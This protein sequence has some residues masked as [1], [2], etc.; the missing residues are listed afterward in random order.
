MLRIS[1]DGRRALAI[2]GDETSAR[3]LEIATGEVLGEWHPQFFD[4]RWAC[5]VIFAPDGEHGY[6]TAMTKDSTGGEL[7]EFD[8][9]TGEETR[10]FPLPSDGFPCGLALHPD[11]KTI[12]QVTMIRR[13]DGSEIPLELNWWD[14]DSARL[15]RHV[16]I[17]TS[18]LDSPVGA[19]FQSVFS[20]DGETLVTAFSESGLVA[21]WNTT[22]GALLQTVTVESSHRIMPHIV[23]SGLLLVSDLKSRLATQVT[24]WDMRTGE[25]LNEQ[26]WE[27]N[28]DASAVSPDGQTLAIGF[29]AA[30]IA[31][32]DVERWQT[33]T[34]LY[35]H[36]YRVW[37]L[38]FTPDGQFLLSGSADGTL[39]LWNLTNGSERLRIDGL[40]NIVGAFDLSPDGSRAAI[41]E[42]GADEPARLGLWDLETGELIR[43]LVNTQ[44]GWR[45]SAFSPDGRRIASL[46][47]TTE[48]FC[49]DV[50]SSLVLTDVDTGS[51]LWQV[52]IDADIFGT[53]AFSGD[54][55]KIFVNEPCEG[56]SMLVWDAATGNSLGEW[57]GHDTL[58]WHIAA[59]PDGTWIA[60][61]SDDA[62]VVLWDAATGAIVKR[63]QH[64][65]PVGTVVF[66]SGSRLLLSA[67]LDGHLH[68]WD[69]AT[70]QQIQQLIGHT[71]SV[72][73][74]QF[75]PNSHFVAS[76]GGDG[77]VFV[78]D[79]R[80][81][82]IVRQFRVPLFSPVGSFVAFSGDGESI[83]LQSSGDPNRIV[84]YDLMLDEGEL[85]SWIEANRYVREITCEERALYRVEP[86]CQPA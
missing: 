34:D 6:V 3:Y 55:S 58:L 45:M 76:A 11:G 16:A 81:G 82:E 40:P 17:D 1:P 86:L 21:T 42:F 63:L 48:P 26:A 19:F 27:V 43:T 74:I 73:S 5:E 75:S 4:D 35:G 32:F 84:Q 50:R 33:I 9:A 38:A 66:D 23:P 56:S 51:E 77:N 78:W 14:A 79:W 36:V 68:V 46:S 60:T 13:E 53:L 25:L 62:T 8:V 72:W 44:N 2:N 47:A 41:Q 22:T 31:L 20:P 57:N 65:N 59:S 54:G 85:M 67:T 29:V 83:Y 71:S 52:E 30:R 37:S 69:L 24:L 10:R 64:D 39:R 70:Y 12:L 7:L 80:A 18:E 61:A 28:T 15:L 49:E